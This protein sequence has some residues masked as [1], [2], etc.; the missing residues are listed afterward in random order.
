MGVRLSKISLLLIDEK[1]T[2]PVGCKLE[3][4]NEND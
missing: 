4:S 3:L 2:A 1:L